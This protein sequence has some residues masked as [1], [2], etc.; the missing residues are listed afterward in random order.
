MIIFSII[1]II[2]IIINMN[3]I[4]IIVIQLAAYR[5]KRKERSRW[6]SVSRDQRNPSRRNFRRVDS[7]VKIP[8]NFLWKTN[9][10]ARWFE[11]NAAFNCSYVYARIRTNCRILHRQALRDMHKECT[12]ASS[13]LRGGA[14]GS[15]Q[16]T[17]SRQIVGRMDE[18][19]DGGT[20]EQNARAWAELRLTRVSTYNSKAGERRAVG[21]EDKPAKRAAC[22]R[23]LPSR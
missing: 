15:E 6:L 7:R 4:V 2:I 13:A 12:L 10:R 11:Y 16:R 19:T 1:I 17:R 20:N 21:C 3:V 5:K 22:S 8:S 23:A 18:R 9:A 14:E